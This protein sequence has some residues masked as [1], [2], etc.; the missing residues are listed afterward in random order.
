MPGGYDLWLGAV[1]EAPAGAHRHILACFSGFLA[2]APRSLEALKLG[3]RGGL[4]NELDG[5]LR[6]SIRVQQTVPLL[7]GIGELRVTKTR[8]KRELAHR[9]QEPRV[10]LCQI[11]RG[12]NLAVSPAFIA[13]F[14]WG[15]SDPAKLGEHHGLTGRLMTA[16][17]GKAPTWPH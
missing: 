2:L 17:G 13:V 7:I 15:I 16:Q 9:F 11:L 14:W 8:Q 6:R 3:S 12:L 5:K 1:L 4:G 10:R